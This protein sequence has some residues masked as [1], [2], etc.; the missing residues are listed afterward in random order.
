M[1]NLNYKTSVR[2]KSSSEPS[3]ASYAISGLATLAILYAT[4]T[5]TPA[6]ANRIEPPR[7]PPVVSDYQR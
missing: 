3:M 4:L 1:Q 5:T 6:K 7:R 2:D